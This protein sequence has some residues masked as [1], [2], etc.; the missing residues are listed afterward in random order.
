LGEKVEVE[1]NE[2]ETMGFIWDEEIIEFLKD[3]TDGQNI[4][5]LYHDRP[6]GIDETL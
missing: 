2:T 1:N 4:Y 5:V 6:L 3:G